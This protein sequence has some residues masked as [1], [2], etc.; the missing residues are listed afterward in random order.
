MEIRPVE[1]GLI[2]ADAANKR[3]CE[4]AQKYCHT[5]KKLSSM[6]TYKVSG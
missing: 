5:N 4:Y 3:L 1:A 6:H 2:I